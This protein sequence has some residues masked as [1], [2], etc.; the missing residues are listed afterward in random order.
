MK[1]DTFKFFVPLDIIKGG[2]D[3]KTGKQTMMVS[4][5]AST[6][7]EDLDGE[8][9]DPKGFDLSYFL[10][11]GLL[12]YNHQASKDPGAII[13][14]PTMAEIRKEGLY[15]EGRLY[16]N[17]LARKVYDKTLELQ[18]QSDTRRMG[19]SIEGKALERDKL[20]PKK[21]LRAAISG[22]AICPSPKNYHTFVEIL[23]KG[24]DCDDPNILEKDDNEDEEE[25]AMSA[26]SETG[27]GLLNQPTTGAALKVESEDPKLKNL[28]FGEKLSKSQAIQYILN[29]KA[30]I[31]ISDADQIYNFT[32][33]KAKMAKDSNS[34]E[35]KVDV[36]DIEKAI[37]L[38]DKAEQIVKGGSSA[39]VLSKKEGKDEDDDDGED[40]EDEMEKAIQLCTENINNKL[41]KSKIYS[42]LMEKGYDKE[43][44][45]VA[46]SEAKNKL[47]KKQEEEA[48]EKQEDEEKEELKKS[49]GEKLAE[50]EILRARLI[51]KG[52]E[53]DELVK[54]S[55]STP[56]VAETLKPFDS[57]EIVKAIDAVTPDT[58]QKSIEEVTDLITDKN[59]SLGVIMK[60]I[61]EKLDEVQNESR[62]AREENEFLKKSIEDLTKGIEQIGS[63]LDMPVERRSLVRTRATE[64]NFEK[65]FPTEQPKQENKNV[66]HLNNPGHRKLALEVV[67]KATFAK[68]VYDE[69][70]GALLT[71]IETFATP[72]QSAITRL[73]LEKGIELSAL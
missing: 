9:L 65:G 18:Q 47:K 58:L 42:N 27:T 7:H 53:S 54:G 31:T 46:Y 40:D 22:C 26:G 3:E 23:Q 16:D 59:Y 10:T 72:S 62:E 63:T 55:F 64:R 33:K 24:I 51:S 21:V 15:L 60:G 8:F 37:A 36:T 66:L 19:F 44:I 52:V 13:G 41:S 69:E 67:D 45:D 20:N 34:L 28:Q 12:N 57:T 29:N 70:Y 4:G 5:I 49:F 17:E 61:Y 30:G 39:D 2:K 1:K 48:A 68:G 6:S 43:K 25:K 14:E 11:S 50:L 73:K 56:L 71:A 32:L 35:A 38:L